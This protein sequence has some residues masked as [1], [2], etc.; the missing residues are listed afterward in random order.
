MSAMAIIV[1][2]G[3]VLFDKVPTMHII[4][5]A[6]AIVIQS[7]VGNLSRIVP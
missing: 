4:H 1:F 7:I 3:I 2:R 6:V 5:I